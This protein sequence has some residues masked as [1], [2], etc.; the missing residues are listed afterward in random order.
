MSAP[1]AWPGAHDALRALWAL[2]P[3]AAFLS[4][5]AFGATPRPV[6]EAQSRR[7]AALAG[8]RAPAR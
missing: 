2:D 1:P 6:L 7:R 3:E 4:R 5:G 8:A